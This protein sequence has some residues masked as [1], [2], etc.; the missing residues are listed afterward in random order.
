MLIQ[1]P[2]GLYMAYRGNVH[3][4]STALTD[5]LYSSHKLLGR[6]H[7]RSWC[8]RAFFIVCAGAPSD[9]PTIERWQK[10]AS[11]ATHWVAL[12]VAASVVPVVGWLGISLYGA[13]DM[14]GLFGMPAADGQN[15]APPGRAS[16]TQYL[17]RS[18]RRGGRRARR[19]R[20][21]PL[22]HPEGWRAD[23]HAAAGGAAGLS[24]GQA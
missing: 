3:E 7:T 17:A 21:V 24:L 4:S 20:D 11:H 9:E 14:F 2:L 18:D 15:Q 6:D 16:T 13:R 8:W 23:A 19:W 12:S 10:G 22:R 1:I 5:A